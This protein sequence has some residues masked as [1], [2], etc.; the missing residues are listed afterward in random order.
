MSEQI[1]PVW[2]ESRLITAFLYTYT[3]KIVYNEIL[4]I[5][6]LFIVLVRYS[7]NTPVHAPMYGL[8]LSQ[9]DQR[10]RSVF[11]L[12]YNS[13]SYGPRAR[14]LRAYFGDKVGLGMPKFRVQ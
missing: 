4:L 9:S 1:F 11:Q 13:S 2:T 14:L 6:V 8:P 7:V 12:V 5:R 3:N 10:I